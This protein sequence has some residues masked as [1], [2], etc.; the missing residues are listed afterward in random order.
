[1]RWGESRRKKGG[2]RERENREK[3]G[4]VIIGKV[5]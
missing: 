1:M 4:G 3:V 5:N 2:W